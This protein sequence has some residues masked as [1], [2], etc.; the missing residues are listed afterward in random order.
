MAKEINFLDALLN[1]I[2]NSGGSGGNWN[3]NAAKR[4][5]AQ[6]KQAKASAP[7]ASSSKTSS[8]KST[9]TTNTSAKQSSSSGNSSASKTSSSPSDSLAFR[10]LYDSAENVSQANDTAQ[11]PLLGVRQAYA[12][13]LGDKPANIKNNENT[14]DAYDYSDTT[15]LTSKDPDDDDSDKYRSEDEGS[16]EGFDFGKAIG[17][18]MAAI[19]PFAVKDANADELPEDSAKSSDKDQQDT[20]T[21]KGDDGKKISP[22]AQE[23][24]DKL[25]E[26]FEQAQKEYEEKK[27]GDVP[28]GTD[29]TKANADGSTPDGEDAKDSEKKNEDSDSENKKKLGYVDRNAEWLKSETGQAYL[30]TLPEDIRK[31]YEKKGVWYLGRYMD[32]ASLGH[33]LSA[34][35]LYNQ[36]HFEDSLG[37][38]EVQDYI[39]EYS[40]YDGKGTSLDANGDG[41]V[42]IEE[43]QK[44]INWAESNNTSQDY[45]TWFGGSGRADA[46]YNQVMQNYLSAYYA[47]MYASIL[48][49]ANDVSMVAN[50]DGSM[51]FI[52]GQQGDK[53]AQT[54]TL[55]PEEAA[56]LDKTVTKDNYKQFIS[57]KQ[58]MDAEGYWSDAYRDFNNLLSANIAKDKLL[59]TKDSSGNYALNPNRK[60][61]FTDAQIADMVN[62][63]KGT[64]Y[65]VTD[66][67]TTR[68]L[69]EANTDGSGLNAL[70]K[71]N[72][73][74]GGSDGSNYAF[75]P[76]EAK[77]RAALAEDPR[78]QIVTDYNSDN[79]SESIRKLIDGED[80][81]QQDVRN[82]LGEDVTYQDAAGGLYTNS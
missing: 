66:A 2:S 39:D 13:D 46:E 57:E 73:F 30:D 15:P 32:D 35:D 41:D 53:N 44:W 61:T 65:G 6:K 56:Q 26:K 5:K 58:P 54:V 34:E 20:Q 1:A 8:P 38:T 55:S 10:P 81:S 12:E 40:D 17:D 78:R 14:H 63:L 25:G 45:T 80:L 62:T 49:G 18:A 27:N 48:S 67:K 82:L 16:D 68:N 70:F 59:Y 75:S 47:N 76:D 43:F 51:T 28:Q 42:S 4:Q 21:E 69:N 37:N 60:S 23:Y 7:K 19:N 9:T 71:Q 79:A 36:A 74:D 64:S 50:D 3:N 77:Q 72:F 22:E 29:N 11:V 24:L 52:D 31:Q 33:A